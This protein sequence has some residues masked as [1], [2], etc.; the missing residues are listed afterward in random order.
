MALQ[1]QRLY[2]ASA[3]RTRDAGGHIMAA[4]NQGR[5]RPADSF[6]RPEQSRLSTI[7]DRYQSTIER[8]D[9]VIGR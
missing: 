2:K 3:G 6:S 8:W 7:I 5:T 4:A 9:W 1:P